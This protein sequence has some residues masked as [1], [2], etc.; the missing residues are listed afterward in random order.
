MEPLQVY[1]KQLVDGFVELY[2]NNKDRDKLDLILDSCAENYINLE[3]EEQILF[4][5]SAKRFVQNYNFLS[6]IL[7]YGSV[8]WEELSIFLNLLINKLP[9]PEKALPYLIE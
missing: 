6:A 5:S 9:R 3:T 7:A 2:L 4:K 8:D 1:T